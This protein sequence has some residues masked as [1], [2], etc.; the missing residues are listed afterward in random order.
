MKHTD[1]FPTV[2]LVVQFECGSIGGGDEGSRGVLWEAS[3]LSA[4]VFL[5]ERHILVLEL[6]RLFCA[7][8]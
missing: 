8:P 2:L 1:A 4:G 3:E 7:V 5:E 6:H